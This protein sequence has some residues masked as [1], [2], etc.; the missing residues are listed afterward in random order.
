MNFHKVFD[1]TLELLSVE[2]NFCKSYNYNV[3]VND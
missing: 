1:Q 2:M 3:F